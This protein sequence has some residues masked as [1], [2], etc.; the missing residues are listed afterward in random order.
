MIESIFLDILHGKRMH[1][2]VYRNTFLGQLEFPQETSS[3]F[4]VW[5]PI[6]YL[7]SKL[8]LAERICELASDLDP[9]YGKVA[10]LFAGSGTVS[11]ALARTRNVVASDMQEYSKVICTAILQPTC[12][13]ESIAIEFLTSIDSH[14]SCLKKYLE[15]ILEYEQ[16]AIENAPR[17]PSMLCDLVEHGSLLD[18]QHTQ[19]ALRSA[20]QETSKRIQKVRQSLLTSQYFGGSYF[21]FMQ[22]LYLDSILVAIDELPQESKTLCLAALL[23]TSSSIVNSIGK[24]FAQPLKPRSKDGKIK[25]HLVA[26]IC[27]DRK[28][29]VGEH[30]CRWLAKYAALP[31]SG[32]HTVCR[33]DFRDVLAS[34]NGV[35]LIYADPPYTRDHYSRY[36][37]VLETLCLR[38]FPDISESNLPNTG[39][40]SRGLYR[41][42]RHQSPFCIKSQA[43]LA[44]SALFDGAKVLGVP[45]LISYSPYIQ[46]GHPRLMTVDAVV[47]LANHAYRHVE[48]L[49]A[50]PI[51][52]SKLNKS[53]LHRD[54]LKSAEVFI[55]CRN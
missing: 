45:L 24:Q 21:S 13:S 53:E 46:N 8:R 15:P 33:G 48:V 38:D 44:F 49:P 55:C 18:F 26:Q 40:K 1:N 3:Q 52:H 36:Y 30:Y 50:D 9:S 17:D 37:H 42:G 10:D 51:A 5:R 20:L 22:S 2:N 35:S 27:R 7:G 41:T 11:L 43:P 47:N 28:L 54:A 31:R 4:E 19:G 29:D 23:S 14:K 12:F 34:L 6:H 25:L 39:R 16:T 32:S